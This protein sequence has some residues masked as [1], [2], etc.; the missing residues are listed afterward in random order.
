MLQKWIKSRRQPKSEEKLPNQFLNEFQG[1]QQLEQST[2]KRF[3]LSEQHFYPCLY[4][5]TSTTAFDRHYVY[6]TA[7][8]VRTVKKINP[9]KHIDVSSSLYFSALLSAF[10]PV[11]FYDYRPANLQLDNLRSGKADLLALP[12]ES[13]SVSS[14]S[15]MH[16]IEHIGL[17]RYGDPLDYDGDLKA[18]QELKRVLSPGGS[19]LF[20]VPLGNENVICFNAHRIYSKAHVLEL[21][22]DFELKEFSLIPEHE[23]DGGLVENPTDD[24]LQKQFY[25]CGCFWFLKK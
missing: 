2:Q 8:A 13:G 21:F 16:T 6:H 15:C 19:L 5:K 10:I 24:L 17:A 22:A 14:L 7:W 9:A 3:E 18:I 11:E 23:E 12:F 4:D 1:L 20:V 25:G